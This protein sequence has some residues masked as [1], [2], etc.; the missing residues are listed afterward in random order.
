M[1]FADDLSGFPAGTVLQSCSIQ[2]YGV[3]DNTVAC[4]QLE[5][6]ANISVSLPITGRQTPSTYID[7]G[8]ITLFVPWSLLPASGGAYTNSLT[9][10]VP[11]SLRSVALTVPDST[12]WCTCAE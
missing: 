6:G 2:Q 4:Q 7:H 10:F 1:T 12:Y 3:P 9:D 5:A 11:M 8:M